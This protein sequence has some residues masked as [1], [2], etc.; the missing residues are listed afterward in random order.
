MTEHTLIGALMISPQECDLSPE[1]FENPSLGRLYY[2]IQNGA[3]ANI[4]YERYRD[5]PVMSFEIQNSLDASPGTSIK[6]PTYCDEIRRAWKKRQVDHL[7][8]CL[9]NADTV[10]DQIEELKTRLEEIQGETGDDGKTIAELVKEYEDKTFTEHEF[11]D[12]G[13]RRLDQYIG[14]LDRG[15]VAVV[16]A[17]PSVGKSAF[18]L[19]VAKNMNRRGLKVAIFNLEMG[20]QQIYQRFL[21]SVSGINMSRIRHAKN[22]Q[23]DEEK[24][25]FKEAN[26]KMAHCT[27][28]VFTGTKTVREI[29]NLSKGFD[30]IIVDYLQLV[31]SKDTYSGNR[32]QEVSEVSRD[33]KNAAQDLNAVVLLLSQLNRASEGKKKL[34]MADLRESG[35][36]EQ[37]ASVIILMWE[38]KNGDRTFSIEKNRQGEKGQVVMEFDGSHM[39]FK[40]TSKTAKEAEKEDEWEPSDENPF[41]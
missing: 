27:I 36:I 29:K 22:F 25:I 1:M 37:D 35:A 28:K 32:V 40:E 19:Q 9:V 38:H 21:A 6:I 33:F 16:G 18:V 26:E 39:T 5:N 34:T 20:D 30:V 14:G 31:R 24:R 12:I 10:D 8:N 23:S 2:D 13:F 4:L 15:D 11:I 3:D 41:E 7:L 17:R